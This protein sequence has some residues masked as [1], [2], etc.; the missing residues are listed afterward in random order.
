[1]DSEF[2]Y[3]YGPAIVFGGIVL[4]LLVSALW[5]YNRGSRNSTPKKQRRAYWVGA[6]VAA[7]VAFVATAEF[8]VP[9]TRDFR[10]QEF[11][12]QTPVLGVLIVWALC[13]LVWIVA[14]W[15]IFRALR[16]KPAQ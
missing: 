4:T 8:A 10:N 16:R 11:H 2:I 15:S 9:I 7:L 6:T 3:S 5:A 1:M 12:N 14:L 13:V